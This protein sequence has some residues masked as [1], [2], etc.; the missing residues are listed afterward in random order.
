MTC[1]L[2]EIFIRQAEYVASLRPIYTR[3]GFLNH[4][5]LMPW[6]LNHV[7]A[8]EEFRLLAWRFTEEVM[9]AL[10]HY[11]LCLDEETF[12]TESCHKH[13]REEVAD[14]LHFFVELCLATGVSTDD[15][16]TYYEGCPL[17]EHTDGL[18][19][20]FRSVGYRAEDKILQRWYFSVEKLGRAMM[21]LKQRPWRTDDRPTNEEAFKGAMAAAFICFISACKRSGINADSLYEAYF[22]KSKINDQR[23][24]DQKL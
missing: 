14:S 4:A 3:N 18:T 17:N 2:K 19:Y 11:R 8:Q 24:A 16:I 1:R 9:E 7:G 12:M 21:L 10:H 23:T 15:L 6:P 22:S 5:S 13:F 20:I